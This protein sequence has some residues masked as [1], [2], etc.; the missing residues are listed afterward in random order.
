MGVA[1]GVW[2]AGLRP[3]A[4]QPKP[5]LAARSASRSRPA[6]RAWLVMLTLGTLSCLACDN[7]TAPREVPP[8][9][10]SVTVGLFHTC[11]IYLGE[12]YC[13]GDDRTG[14]LGARSV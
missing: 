1:R 10:S 12:A 5:E 13:F 9:W 6:H 7:G 14:Q 4:L 2:H 3:R 11:G 8:G